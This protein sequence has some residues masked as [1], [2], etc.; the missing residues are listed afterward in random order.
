MLNQTKT[1]KILKDLQDL[2]LTLKDKPKEVQENPLKDLWLAKSKRV[3]EEIALLTDEER[4]LLDQTYSQWW[5][6]TDLEAAMRKTLKN[7]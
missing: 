2:I 3:R 5:S 7:A 6:G 4:K 1:N